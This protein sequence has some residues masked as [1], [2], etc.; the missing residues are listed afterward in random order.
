MSLLMTLVVGIFL[1]V[2][3]ITIFVL[4]QTSEIITRTLTAQNCVFTEPLLRK[5]VLW[6]YMGHYRYHESNVKKNS[7]EKKFFDRK[8]FE[9]FLSTCSWNL[10][11]GF[12]HFCTFSNFDSDIPIIGLFSVIYLISNRIIARLGKGL[13]GVNE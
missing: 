4:F 7:T 6:V 12:Y 11:E 2:F 9:N 3:D 13:V 1:R 8:F 10:F 5:I